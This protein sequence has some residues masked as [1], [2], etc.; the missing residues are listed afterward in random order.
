[1]RTNLFLIST[2]IMLSLMSMSSCANAQN[3]NGRDGKTTVRNYA[4][5]PFDV[6]DAETVANIVFVQATETTVRAEGNERMIDNISITFEEDKLK[7]RMKDKS[8]FKGKRKEEANLT[9][10]ISSP[11]LVKIKQE[12][13]GTFTLKDKVEVG[14]L[15]I[16]FEGVGNFVTDNLICSNL[17]I[18]YEGVGN[19]KL[20]GSAINAKYNSEGVGSLSAEN[21]DVEHLIVRA[22]GVG[23]VKCRAS[24][25]IDVSS[26]GVGSVTYWGNPEVKNLSKNG[27]GKIKAAGI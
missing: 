1:M 6:I 20:A 27:V 13:V 21:F 9:I 11:K 22:S 23:S 17:K 16:D 7:I 4:A 18:D 3:N 5:K 14:N 8:I 2:A 24:K 26:D 19:I 10:Y 15:E 12:G 25:T